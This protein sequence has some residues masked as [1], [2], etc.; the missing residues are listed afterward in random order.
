[1]QKAIILLFLLFLINC[2]YKPDSIGVPNEIIILSSPEDK[3]LI[4][5]FISNVFSRKIQ[6]PQGE[7]ILNL[8]F[9][10]P[11]EFKT[12]KTHSNLLI[13]SLTFPH[14]STGDILADRFIEKNNEIKNSKNIEIYAIDNLFAKDQLISIVRTLDLSS[15]ANLLSVNQEW[16]FDQHYT[17]YERIIER[18]IFKNGKNH[19]LST[20]ILDLI[21]FTIDLQIDF[22][23]I[24]EN[25]SQPFVWVGRGYP[26]RWITIHKSNKANYIKPIS[27]W[28]QLEIEY[29]KYIKNIQISKYYQKNEK[30]IINEQNIRVMRGLYEHEESNTGGP[31]FVYIFDIK[32]NNE[33]ILVSGFVNN[34]GQNKLFLLKQLEVIAKTLNRSESK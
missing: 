21:G 8:Q 10:N 29:N 5:S 28:E 6:T 32:E 1:M 25:S 27:S 15:F 13:A 11:W 7:N 3:I 22:K 24:E 30:R 14:D 19:K 18:D 34:P 17:N 33:V 9:R 31:F 12:V 16:L 23:L 20:I 4:E 2:N 26:Y